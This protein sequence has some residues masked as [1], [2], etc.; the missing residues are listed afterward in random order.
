MSAERPGLMVVLIGSFLATVVSAP[1]SSPPSSS[2]TT[3]VLILSRFGSGPV[4]LSCSDD[5]AVSTSMTLAAPSSSELASTCGFTTPR[6]SATLSGSELNT[7]GMAVT[8][9][10]RA[11]FFSSFHRGR[12]LSEAA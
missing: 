7:V 1:S 3:L 8:F 5:A 6:F 9:V 2:P 11:Y 10:G 12:S 4:D